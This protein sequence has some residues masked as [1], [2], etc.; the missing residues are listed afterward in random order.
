MEAKQ[1]TAESI[2]DVYDWVNSANTG[3]VANNLTSDSF[4]LKFGGRTT[5]VNLSSW[6]VNFNTAVGTIAVI[7][8][9]QLNERFEQVTD[10]EAQSLPD[11]GPPLGN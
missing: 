8:D 5:T 1:V 10:E 11:R 6:V 2:N 7:P 9:D 4:V 3:A